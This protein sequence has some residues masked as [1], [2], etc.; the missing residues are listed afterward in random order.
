MSLFR[1]AGLLL[2]FAACGGNNHNGQSVC[3]NQVPPPVECMTAC[4]PAPGAANTCPTG[5]HCTPDGHC[6][7]LCTPGGDECGGGYH[8]SD[9]GNCVQNGDDG[10]VTIDMPCP[11][12]VFTPMKTTPSVEL[13]VDRSGSMNGTDFPPTRFQA[14]VSALFG[15]GGAVTGNQA[16]VFF[17]A[18]MYA[19]DQ[20][21]PALNNLKT[22][23]ALNNANAI[24]T[25]LTNNPP[26]NGST[27]TAD[28]VNAAV[29]DYAA[30]PPPAGS[31]PYILLTT[32]GLPNSCSNGND[33]GQSVN[34]AKA[35]FNAGIQLF[36]LGLAG[37][38]DQFLQDMANA[39]QG[40]NT[41]QNPGCAQCA[42]FFTANDPAQ[43]TAALNAII[44]GIVSCDLMLNGTIDDGQAA[45]GT[46]T[47]NGMMLMFG[48]DWILVNGNII[49][50]VGA[51][52]DN[53]K[54]STNPTVQA[55][56]PCGSVILKPSH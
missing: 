32:D 34:A 29:A 37:I 27:P 38:N 45:S 13:V 43:L 15:A 26:I 31:P 8:C 42:P 11:A 12:V 2:L 10:G 3:Q 23:R 30:A 20:P 19:G 28:A 33:N 51:A 35:A 56:F 48:T 16:N 1:V 52:C 4:D 14:E 21:C 6:D 36:I 47:V 25:L 5:Y 17:G 40:L 50:L 24:Q 18:L 39:G 46:V 22:A 9:D 44:N 54:N 41:G 49:R 7:A 53:F 55:T